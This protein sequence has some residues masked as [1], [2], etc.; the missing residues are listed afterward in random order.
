MSKAKIV[1]VGS[2]NADLTTYVP[3][4]PRPGESVIGGKFVTGPGGKGSNQAVAAARLGADVTFI[5][6]VG[7]DTFAQT[8]LDIWRKEGI[9]TDF[10]AQKADDA[11]GVALIMVEESGEN[12]ISVA[13]GANLL[14]GPGDLDVAADAIAR[15]DVLIVQ[16]EV[17]YETTAYALKLAKQK[18]I[19][20]ILN[21]APAGHLSPEVLALADYI[22]PNE[23]ELEALSG[24]VSVGVEESA[25]KLL[26]H[27]QQTVVV[28]LGAQGAQW[29]R[30]DGSGLLPTFHV[31]VVDT[32]G[33]GDAFN[34]GL[35]VALAEGRALSDAIVFANAVA[36]LCV[37]KP[38]T[39]N[40]MPRRDEV[41]TLLKHT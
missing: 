13:P 25:R 10:V 19:R 23:T 6:C 15:A 18:G 8:A 27:N 34:G 37:T 28:T 35:A 36:A 39:A 7:Q 22:T 2:F 24:Q 17:R 1:V 29:V 11:T 41:E 26:A 40:S 38:G 32:T 31:D 33:A 3:H 9:H 20:T 30:Y 14:L 21:P 16:L 5:G 4:L 12:L